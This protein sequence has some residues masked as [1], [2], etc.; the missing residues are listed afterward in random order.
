MVDINNV[1]KI[2][3]IKNASDIHLICGIKPTLRIERELIQIDDMD[4]LEEEDVYEIYDYFIR[5]NIDKDTEFKKARKLDIIYEH[6]NSSLRVNISY[7]NEL[8]AYT[9]KIMKESLP[10]YEELGIPEIVREMLNK[11]QGLILVTGRSN[12]GKTTTLNSLINEINETKNKKVVVLENLTEY[13]HIQKK[14]VI[15]QKEIGVGKD[16]LNYKDALKNCINEDADVVVIEEIANK[17]VMDA[18]IEI[19]ES[20][21]LVIGTLTSKTCAEAVERIINF[22][23]NDEQTNIKYLISSLIKLVIS[24]RLLKDKH[25][26]IILVPEV[27]VVDNSIAKVLKKENFELSEIEKVMQENLEKGNIGLIN[28]IAKLF[29]EEKITLEQAKIQV[30]DRNIE[31]LNNAI[32]QLKIKK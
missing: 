15:V 11:T 31:N 7:T 17:E 1:I 10:T 18:V 2:A 20:G 12:S 26:K 22:Y 5:G 32:M 21:I 3:K 9:L 19:A 4:I 16:C 23:K 24:Q 30:E 8:P 28:S 6:E 25:E 14:S 29:I 27:M 13:K